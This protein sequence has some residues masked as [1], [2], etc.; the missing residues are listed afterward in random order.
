MGRPTI[1]DL[2]EAAGVSVSTVNRILSGNASVRGTTM[3]R[4]QSA[5]EE[6]GF[7][8]VGA[9]EDRLR[10]AAPNFRLGFLLQQSGRELYQLFSRH[11][12]AAC[13]ARRDEVV[14]PVVD[15]VDL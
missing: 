5:A 10:K 3:Q 6:I 4:V 9:I 11:I 2:A 14:D 12:V 15:F 7:Y 1:A 8:G 13:R